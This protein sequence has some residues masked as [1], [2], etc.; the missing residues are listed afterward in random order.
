MI[1]RLLIG[2]L[3]LFLDNAIQHVS[4]KNVELLV[5]MFLIQVD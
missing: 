3:L 5:K 2:R 1:A 4:S